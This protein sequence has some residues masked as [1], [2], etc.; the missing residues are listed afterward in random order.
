MVFAPCGCE[1]LDQANRE[2]L[3]PAREVLLEQ[4]RE[5]QQEWQCPR[6]GG[7]DPT[8]EQTDSPLPKRCHDALGNVA[9][10]TGIAAIEGARTCPCSYVMQP[11]VST[12]LEARAWAE[13]G[14]LRAFCGDDPP[15][16]LFDAIGVVDA[17]V[18]A[19]QRHDA[20]EMKRRSEE[21]QAEIEARKSRR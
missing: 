9:R 5:A 20:D 18:R 10:L 16:T 17:A 12:T 2:A 7:P 3:G 1:L 4:A 13:R 15:A 19:R 11:G 21:R 14:E 6:S 8:R